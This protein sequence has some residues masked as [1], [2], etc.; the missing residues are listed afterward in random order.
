MPEWACKINALRTRLGLSGTLFAAQLG[1]SSMAVSRWERGQNEPAADIYLA[2][3]KMAGD[4]DCWYFWQR[5]GLTIGDIL[6][7]LPDAQGRMVSTSSTVKLEVIPARGATRESTGTK[8][9][10]QPDLVAVALLKDAAAAGSPRLID[11]AAVEDVLVF[12]RRSIPHPES[13]ICLRIAGESMTPI[14]E[15]GFVVCVDTH[16]QDHSHLYNEMVAARD[17]DGGVTVKW[18]RKV[19]ADD[20]LIA[21]HTSPRFPPVLLSREPGWRIIGRVLFWIGRPK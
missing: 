15:D 2:I 11:S 10:T 9:K 1:V 12:R 5:A 17:P 16:E 13:T 4:P 19:G 6:K 21:Q 14:L 18:L 7:V 8:L 20:M 3:G